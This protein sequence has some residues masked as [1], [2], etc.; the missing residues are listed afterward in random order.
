[1]KNT[2]KYILIAGLTS[3]MFSCVPQRK[4]EEEQSK[5]QS[6]ETE[7]AALKAKSENAKK[8]FASY[9]KGEGINTFLSPAK[10]KK[11]STTVKPHTSSKDKKAAIEHNKAIYTSPYE[12]GI[13]DK[14][15][16]PIKHKGRSNKNQ[17]ITRLMKNDEEAFKKA[18]K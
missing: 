18:N 3:G 2:F 4:L 6:C 7:L 10:K 12:K 8:E 13:N 16:L 5:R 1:M 11:T 9:L 17:E 14:T 15:G